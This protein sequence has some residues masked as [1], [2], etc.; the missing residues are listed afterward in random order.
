MLTQGG[1]RAR[2]NIRDRADVEDDA[3]VGQLPE[4]PRIL[5]R[6]DPV[7]D[8][9]GAERV[10]RAADR[11]RPRVLAGMR[12]RGEA[13]G[14]GEL[15]RGCIR[16]RRMLG[17]GPAEPHPDDA[18]VAVLDREPDD[19]QRLFEA[20]DARDIRRQADLDPIPLARLD[21]T[22][23]DAGEDHVAVEPSP[24]AE[25]EDRL[26]IDGAVMDGFGRV[27]DNDLPEV[28]LVLECARRQHE[29]LDEVGEV[30][31]LV[32][33]AEAFDRIGRQGVAVASCDFEQ[34]LRTHRPLEVDVELDLRVR[35][36]GRG[37]V[38]AF[39]RQ[40]GSRNE[41]RPIEST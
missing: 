39:A 10:E 35:H 1:N 37:A 8:A 3:P 40:R 7:P 22:V 32:E 28:L 25:R 6:P 36:S 14:A 20:V 33:R 41:A 17:L 13:F 11:A 5:D 23:A 16:L 30:A 21:G 4:Q 34:R 12:N 24:E 38:P 31:V 19:L 27:V 15:E 9:T 29:D 18:S 26:Q 2:A